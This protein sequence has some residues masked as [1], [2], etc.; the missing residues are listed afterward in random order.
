MQGRLSSGSLECVPLFHQVHFKNPVGHVHFDLLRVDFDRWRKPHRSLEGAVV[1]F[2]HHE[3]VGQMCKGVGV[4]ATDGQAVGVCVVGG[5]QVRRPHRR[6]TCHH[7]VH[8]SQV[9]D[10]DWWREWV[11]MGVWERSSWWRVGQVCFGIV[12]HYKGHGEGDGRLFEELKKSWGRNQ[13]SSL[14]KSAFPSQLVA[15]IEPIR[16]HAHAMTSQDTG[17]IMAGLILALL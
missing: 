6:Q 8:V 9:V 15:Y 17:I 16:V 14:K 12:G 4:V 7:N 5:F 10:V 3:T 2:S 13:V 11:S 1:S